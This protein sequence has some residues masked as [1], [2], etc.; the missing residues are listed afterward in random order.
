MEGR[1]PTSLSGISTLEELDLAKNNLSGVIPEELSSLHELAIFDVSSSN[2]S[3]PIPTWT[4]FSTF[5]VSSFQNNNCLW[6]CPLDSCNENGRQAIKYHNDS[7][8]GN[9]RVRWFSRVDENMS[10]IALGMGMGIGFG[11]FFVL[12]MSWERAKH[13]VVPQTFHDPFFECMD[14]LHRHGLICSR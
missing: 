9:V 13:W 2:L 12:F 3:G 5:N 11:G 7:K 4:Q 14:F 8:V 1:I 6:G 10:L